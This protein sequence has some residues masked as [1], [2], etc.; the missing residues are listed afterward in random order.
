[1][2][3]VLLFLEARDPLI[4]SDFGIFPKRIFQIQLLEVK[5]FFGQLQGHA[6][7]IRTTWSSGFKAPQAFDA[8]LHIAF[9]GGGISRISLAEDL[10]EER[11]NS[12]SAS[13][14]YDHPTENYIFGFTLEGFYTSL[15]DAFFLAPL[16][17]DAFGERFEKQNGETARV[18]GMTLEVR[19]NY[20][21]KIQLEINTDYSMSDVVNAH[22]DLELRKTTGSIVMKNNY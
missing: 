11:S 8:D 15:N 20:K 19:A 3:S 17:E 4:P 14:N 16:G 1:M 7:Q 10:E 18:Q 22:S 9:A 21:N 5:V 6:L 13:I 12:F 2:A